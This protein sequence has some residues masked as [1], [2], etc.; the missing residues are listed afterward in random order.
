MTRTYDLDP[1]T[2]RDACDIADVVNAC[3][4][5]ARVAWLTDHND[6]MEGTMRS[7][8]D[9][10]GNFLRADDEVRDAFVRITTSMG[11]EVFMP[12]RDAM[13]LVHKSEM[14]FDS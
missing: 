3:Q 5:T 11:M 6:R 10:R 8:G 7:V 1:L 4:R 2:L 9:E 13:R 14:V 12:M